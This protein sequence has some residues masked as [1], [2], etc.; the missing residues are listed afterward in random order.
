[1]L[2]L[3]RRHLKDC[4]NESQG[5]QFKRCRNCQI[6]IQGTLREKHANARLYAVDVRTQSYSF[7]VWQPIVPLGTRSI[8]V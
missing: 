2:V 7:A 4:R 3:Y 5:R 1:M 6:W 8:P